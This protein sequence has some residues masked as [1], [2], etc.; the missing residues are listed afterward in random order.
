[1]A[2]IARSPSET[3][4]TGYGVTL[5]DAYNDLIHTSELNLTIFDCVF[6]KVHNDVIKV[7]I[8]ENND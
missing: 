8:V 5:V 4:F 3:Q 6:Y 2:Y 7:T 1:M